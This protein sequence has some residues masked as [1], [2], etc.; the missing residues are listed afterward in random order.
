MAEGQVTSKGKKG[1]T[2]STIVGFFWSFS[3]TGIQAT[4]HFLVFAILSRLVTPAEF[5]LVNIANILT[6]FA[7]LFYQLGIG[8]SIIQRRELRPEHIQSGFTLTIIL[9]AVLTGLSWVFAPV[10]ASFFDVQGLVAVLRGLS[11]LFILNSFGLVARALNYRNL[12][13]KIKAKINAA[14][15][16]VGYG[17]IGVGLAAFGFGVWALVWAS[18]SQSLMTSLLYLKASPHS[19]AFQ[20]NKR[21]L[22]DLLSFGTGVTLGQ[23]FNRLANTSDNLIV[24]ATLGARAVGLYGRAYQLMV[25]PSQYFG[26]VLDSVLYT[27]MAKVQDQPKTLGAVYRRGVVA[28]ALVVMPMSAF[29]FILAPEFVSVLVGK[30]WGDVIVPFKIFA[31]TMLFRTSYKMGDSLC[32]S[33]GIVF[34]RALRQFLFSV[35]IVAGAFFGHY[36]GIVGVTVGV[37]VAITLNFFS[38]AQLSFSITDTTWIQFF[39]IHLPAAVF[40][41]IVFCETWALAGFL[42]GFG[43]A[44]ISVLFISAGLVGATLLSMIWFAP[45]LFLGKDGLWM[46]KTFGGY[47]PAPFQ[48]QVNRLLYR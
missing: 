32:R 40:T 14:T 45:K 5:G 1:L 2:H 15:Y 42:R 13:F 34:Q 30:Q 4:L 16:V 9:G 43:W 26:Q 3:S 20:L 17:L 41:V 31:V 28:I 21:A 12:N 19:F 36:Y 48:K 27:A 23:I 44:D 39:R 7:G 35:M 38:M 46:L 18:L 8:P 10:F 11:F 22:T 29:L 6:V 37:S 25:L 47:L 24:G 33:A